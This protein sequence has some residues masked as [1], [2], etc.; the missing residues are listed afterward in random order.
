MAPSIPQKLTLEV[1][2]TRKNE[3]SRKKNADSTTLLLQNLLLARK[4]GV[5]F[6]KMMLSFEAVPQ[7][8][9]P[10]WPPA[11][12]R[13]SARIPPVRGYTQRGDTSPFGGVLKTSRTSLTQ[14][15]LSRP[16]SYSHYTY[17]ESGRPRHKH[18]WRQFS[19]RLAAANGF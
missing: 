2:K 5:S 15:Q 9:P 17:V 6:L 10:K 4:N 18:A 7:S 8:W 13:G 16:L 14:S 19:R 11:A 12:S 3:G 1:L